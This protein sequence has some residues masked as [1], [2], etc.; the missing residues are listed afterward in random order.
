MKKSHYIQCT[1]S[2]GDTEYTAY[3]P[4]HGAKVGHSMVLEGKEGR[5]TVTVVSKD[6]R[7]DW[8][9]ALRRSRDYVNQRKASDI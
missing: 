6:T 8:E 2:Q 3:I 7:I 1:F 9:M 5:W 4:E